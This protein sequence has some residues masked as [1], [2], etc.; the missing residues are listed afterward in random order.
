MLTISFLPYSE[1]ENL[2]PYQRIKK[3]LN[4]VK[5]RK[6]LILEG[7]LRREEEAELIKVTMEEIDKTFK[8]IELAVIYPGETVGNTILTKVRKG[9]LNALLG[10]R[11][12]LTIIGPA[13]VVKEIKKDPKNIELLTIDSKNG[14]RKSPIPLK[15]ARKPSR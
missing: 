8:G 5:D 15:G 14:K 1:I 13:T 12:G 6:I 4:I 2:G 3:I 7:R 10:D 9:V 11:Q